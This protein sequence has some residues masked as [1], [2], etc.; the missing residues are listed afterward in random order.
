VSSDSAP[1]PP[2]HSQQSTQTYQSQQHPTFHAFPSPLSPRTALLQSGSHRG[3][4]DLNNNIE[5]FHSCLLSPRQTILS[6]MNAPPLSPREIRLRTVS[7]NADS[8]K[9][10][11]ARERERE[12]IRERE[13]LQKQQEKQLEK[14]QVMRE[15]RATVMASPRANNNSSDQNNIAASST[16]VP[17]WVH[18][19]SEARLALSISDIRPISFGRFNAE[20][21]F[22]REKEKEILQAQLLLSP[23]QHI[24]QSQSRDL[25]GSVANTSPDN[26]TTTLNSITLPPSASTSD[27]GSSIATILPSHVKFTPLSPRTRA[28]SADVAERVSQREDARAMNTMSNS[29]GTNNIRGEKENTVRVGEKEQNPLVQQQQQATDS[30]R[31]LRSIQISQQSSVERARIMS[32]STPSLAEYRGTVIIQQQ[33]TNPNGSSSPSPTAVLSSASSM[34]LSSLSSNFSDPLSQAAANNLNFANRHFS[35][36]PVSPMSPPRTPRAFHFDPKSVTKEAGFLLT[37]KLARFASEG[38]I[39]GVM[40][41]LLHY[42]FLVYAKTY[43][44][45]SFNLFACL[46]TYFYSFIC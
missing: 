1:T 29:A 16:S 7:A 22:E 4:A 19:P 12:E 14:Q 10:E 17:Q 20:T 27:N 31:A 33:N 44:G 38:F 25:T 23:R 2:V 41:L 6:P 9:R 46:L 40:K 37:H 3:F 26:A 28:V 39:V 34:S 21:D 13:R 15:A 11:E 8:G 30:F 35:L 45:M 42:P 5:Q 24:T 43:L 36:P 18:T 32:L